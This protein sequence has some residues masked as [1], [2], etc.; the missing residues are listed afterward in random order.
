MR[1]IGIDPSLTA[2]GIAIIDTH[3]PDTIHATT[4]K[5]TNNGKEISTRLGRFTD[6]IDRLLDHLSNEPADE[7]VIIEAPS[8]GSRGA[9][10]WDRAG[11][12]WRIV[13]VIHDRGTTV[14]EIPP[15]VRCKY[16]T[17]RGNADKDV[18][19]LSAAR[20]YPHADIS[21]NNEADAVILAAIGARLT[22]HPIDDPMPKANLTG[23]YAKLSAV[24]NPEQVT[25]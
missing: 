25:A 17:G 4:I 2:T 23:G 22:G 10:I 19:M 11:L 15:A 3:N 18:V 12:W 5:T 1:I 24:F 20:R 21:N 7:L 8:Y 6:I 13:R 9:G 14:I 16:A